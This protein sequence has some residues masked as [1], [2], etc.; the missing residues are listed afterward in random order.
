MDAVMAASTRISNIKALK[1]THFFLFLQDNVQIVHFDPRN[2]LTAEHPSCCK[3]HTVCRNR[4]RVCC[5]L[6]W[7]PTPSNQL[8][9]AGSTPT[10]RKERVRES[11]TDGDN[12]GGE[13]LESKKTTDILVSQV[14]YGVWSPCH[15]MST[16]VL[17]GWNPRPTPPPSP[18]RLVYEGAIGQPRQTTSL[19]DPLLGLLPLRTVLYI[20]RHKNEHIIPVK[21][22]K[23]AFIAWSWG[24]CLARHRGMGRFIW[25]VS[26][27]WI[28]Y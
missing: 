2:L 11:H 4:T 20:L 7:L 12:W 17:I 3:G 9:L 15:V 23:L 13:M 21:L 1:P 5:R 24:Y 26:K 18:R 8:G 10:Q 28:L 27:L 14:K 16:A 25:I 22:T 6:F 19:C